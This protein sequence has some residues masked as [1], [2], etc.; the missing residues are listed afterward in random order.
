MYS[1]MV[2][3]LTSELSVISIN[4]AVHTYTHMNL[5]HVH[6]LPYRTKVWQEKTSAN[7]ANFT[8]SLNFI[9]QTFCNSLLLS[10]F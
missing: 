5:T 4:K 2:G 1:C 7:L 8:K 3:G 10:V 6:L 9:C